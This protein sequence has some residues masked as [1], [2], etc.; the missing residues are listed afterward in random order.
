MRP[1]PLPAPANDLPI[2]APPIPADTAPC[3]PQ[4]CRCLSFNQEKKWCCSLLGGFPFFRDFPA[5]FYIFRNFVHFSTFSAILR[6]FPHFPQF[7]RGPPTPNHLS[8][9]TGA[10][11]HLLCFC[12]GQHRSAAWPAAAGRRPHP[13]SAAPN[14][15]PMWFPDPVPLA[16]AATESSSLEVII[17]PPRVLVLPKVSDPGS[18][19]VWLTQGPG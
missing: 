3:L 9:P 13:T 15:A 18:L 6:I 19:T 16:P 5:L 2:P 8:P 14:S 12:R 4:A 17:C 10:R 1:L 11:G 7:P